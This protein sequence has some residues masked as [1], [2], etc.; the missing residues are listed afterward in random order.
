MKMT[1]DQKNILK[2]IDEILWN[3]WGPIGINGVEVAVCQT[4]ANKVS[5]S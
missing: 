2:A 5:I 4:W 3:D 1:V